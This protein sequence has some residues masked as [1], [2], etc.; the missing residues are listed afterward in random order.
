MFRAYDHYTVKC[1][2]CGHIGH[3]SLLY[4]GLTALTKR[5]SGF[6][7]IRTDYRNPRSSLAACAQCKSA[8]VVVGRLIRSSA[9][10][11]PENRSRSTAPM[12]PH[13]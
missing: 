2:R 13:N 10:P 1:R 12:S 4:K 3:L 8:D 11:E 7:P 9:L 5:W 6:E